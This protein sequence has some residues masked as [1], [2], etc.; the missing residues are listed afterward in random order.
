MNDLRERLASL[1]AET[2]TYIQQTIVA[3]LSDAGR[4][5]DIHFLLALETTEHRNSW[6]DA[7]D[8][9]YD[10]DGYV[11]DVT[12]AW[13]IAEK[14][15]AH[16][17]SLRSAPFNDKEK[18]SFS[19]LFQ[20][21]HFPTKFKGESSSE[22]KGQSFGLE[23]RYGLIIASVNSIATQVPLDLLLAL[24]KSGSW[25]PTQALANVRRTDLSERGK[26][27]RA[28]IPHLPVSYLKEALDI[29][30]QMTSE[31][32]STLEVLVPRLPVSLIREVVRDLEIRAPEYSISVLIAVA[33]KLSETERGSI[34]RE[35]LNRVQ[36]IKYTSS[37]N[38]NSQM[39]KLL[40][41]LAANFSN[42]G[43]LEMALEAA[44][45]ITDLHLRVRVLLSLAL[46]LSEPTKSNVLHEILEM[47]RAINIDEKDYTDERDKREELKSETL[48]YLVSGMITCE[49]FDL[50]LE[51][52]RSI[53][54]YQYRGYVYRVDALAEL[55]PHLSE[56]MKEEVLQDLFET[57]TIYWEYY[58]DLRF[59][60]AWEEKLASVLIKMGYAQAVLDVA[61]DI[62]NHYSSWDPTPGFAPI[63]P[64]G[65]G[66]WERALLAIVS[67]LPEAIKDKMLR[68]TL[69]RAR[70]LSL[71]W[72]QADILTKLFPHLPEPLREQVLWEVL[73]I[74]RR[75][76]GSAEFLIEIV[77]SAAKA[78]YL[79]QV[80]EVIL[81]PEFGLGR[82]STK[83]T[84]RDRERKDRKL[85]DLSGHL[86][87]LGYPKEALEVVQAIRDNDLRSKTDLRLFPIL[88]EPLKISR[89]S[90]V[91]G[92]VKTIY[93]DESSK[94][95]ES[96]ARVVPF[97]PETLRSREL[98]EVLKAAPMDDLSSSR[99]TSMFQDLEKVGYLSE[100]VEAIRKIRPIQ[101][102][103]NLLLSF[104]QNSQ[105]VDAI[106]GSVLREVLRDLLS[107]T[108]MLN[109]RFSQEEIV[110]ELAHK[111]GE[112]GGAQEALRA[113][114]SMKD[115]YYQ[116]KA[117]A[118]LI[119]YL[120]EPLKHQ[121][122][123][124]IINTVKTFQ[125]VIQRAEVIIL[126]L[127]HLPESIKIPLS[128]ETI[129]ALQKDQD[130]DR[131]GPLMAKLA[132]F[133]PEPLRD[134]K[135]HEIVKLVKSYEYNPNVPYTDPEKVEKWIAELDL[136]NEK[137]RLAR[138]AKLIPNLTEA[139]QGEVIFFAEIILKDYS[140]RDY[141]AITLE[142]LA[143]YLSESLLRKTINVI[144]DAGD[145][146]W[147][148][149]A[150]LRRLA[151]LGYPHEA[152]DEAYHIEY[153]FTRAR[154]LAAL[155]PYLPEKMLYSTL[156]NI[157]SY[158]I[159]HS[160]LDELEALISYIIQRPSSDL[161]SHWF[162]ILH[163]FS[164]RTRTELLVTT[165]VL[166]PILVMLG[167]KEA[168]IEVIRAIQDAGRWWP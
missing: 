75:D 123:N 82:E 72:E 9:F 57:W 23:Y 132:L 49:Y 114:Q 7:T 164:T 24:V 94:R 80:L 109:D 87:Y 10:A 68:E 138:L 12:R 133:L 128:T 108:P 141:D 36:L 18:S 59:K 158:R 166:I 85:A 126:L 46:Y 6:Y 13:R 107:L 64:M 35:I 83:E 25:N 19:R 65:V 58:L 149:P 74:V 39:E 139:L 162:D 119:P 129:E 78:G 93:K 160:D 144:K 125:D 137:E 143:P 152:L 62:Y 153:G 92:M 21:F 3:H 110:M 91:L 56:P 150:L 14:A 45:A 118:Q 145:H 73:E 168:I 151:E 147:M 98:Y 161:V 50:A 99:L 48:L 69:D 42:W 20:L 121:V 96:L 115:N 1:K 67:Y 81:A 47:A 27:L 33:N 2:G 146:T 124:E 100:A 106:E 163:V 66:I 165:R 71:K 40:E 104:L 88:P 159:G 26:V 112:L 52:A 127:P 30:L 89:S 95:W 55:V 79:P 116:V 102:R 76:S 28:L 34:V 111:L 41:T 86:L 105:Q 31:K 16:A 32:Q 97:L 154:A 134:E 156:E 155:A 135:L 43:Y 84:A 157:L 22:P 120:N 37:F 103:R 15:Y 53:D 167:G 140:I 101:T 63:S 11:A 51:A 131:Q 61:Q 70:K 29:V 5:E 60:E 122:I 142:D 17:S 148:L 90:E 8:A 130:D 4:V 54:K 136:N 113:V 44:R 38:D 77:T 117:T